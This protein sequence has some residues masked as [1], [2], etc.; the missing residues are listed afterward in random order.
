[1]ITKNEAVFTKDQA[2]KKL[3]VVRAFD[4]PLA[5]VWKAWTDSDM[6]DQ[7]WAPKPYKAVTKSMDFKPG[8][9]WLYSMVGPEGDRNF[10]RVDF[11]TIDPNKNFAT[12]VMFC[13]EAG[14]ENTEFPKM[15]WTATF[16][17][18]SSGTAVNIDIT[19]DKPEDMETFIK[20]GFQEGFTAGLNNLDEIL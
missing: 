14:N 19:F 11:R 13:D 5:E 16:T 3:T 10:C 17:Q 12:A 8:G 1:M 15:Y 20:M 7:W 18:T 2:N 9:K 6:L 4:A